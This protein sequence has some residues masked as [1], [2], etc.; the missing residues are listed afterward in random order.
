MLAATPRC[1]HQVS[2][3]DNLCKQCSSV[4]HLNVA[5]C[6]LERESTCQKCIQFDTTDKLIAKLI[7]LMVSFLIVLWNDSVSRRLCHGGCVSAKV[8]RTSLNSSGRLSVGCSSAAL[9]Y[10]SLLD[11]VKGSCGGGSCSGWYMG[12]GRVRCSGH[13][14]SSDWPMWTVRSQGASFSPGQILKSTWLLSWQISEQQL[15]EEN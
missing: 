10:M 9:R 5:A 1:R 12:G 3:M 8:R 14:G 11:G 6:C 4:Q 7:L 15:V 13:R 2:K